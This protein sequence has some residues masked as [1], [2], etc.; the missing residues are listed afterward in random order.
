MNFQ[1]DAH[2]I[3][4]PTR[5][6][7]MTPQGTTRPTLI[8]APYPADFGSNL[9]DYVAVQFDVDDN[10]VPINLRAQSP[11]GTKLET[12]AIEIVSGGRFQPGM[13]DGKPV[14]VPYWIALTGPQAHPAHR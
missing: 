1:L 3:R 4:R 9:S 14:S 13:K 12:E 10:G 2:S 11:S 7:F 8:E 5:A 6:N